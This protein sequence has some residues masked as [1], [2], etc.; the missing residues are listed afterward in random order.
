MIDFERIHERIRRVSIPDST[1]TGLFW[2]PDSKK[3]AFTGTV[4]GKAGIYTIEFPDDLKPKLLTTQAGC[5]ARWLESGNQI[6]WLS[7]GV[8][9]SFRSGGG[10]AA[11]ASRQPVGRRRAAAGRSRGGW[12]GYRFRALQEVELARA[13]T[14][15]RSTCAWRTMRDRCY[16]ER[17]RQPELGRRPPQV[18]RHG[19]AVARPRDVRHGRPADARRAERLAPRLH[20]ATAGTAPA[21]GP[22][23]AAV[24]AVPGPARPGTEG[25]GDARWNVAT[26]HLGL[27]FEPDYQ[28]ARA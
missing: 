28:G 1:E 26:A 3:L 15:R 2:S 4:D 23:P 25:A 7:G 6:V 21:P 18:C 19:R 10:G 17:P 8:P 11:A 22:V 13:S 5:Q 27:R 20:A 24:R 16:D 9:A 14:A 12:G